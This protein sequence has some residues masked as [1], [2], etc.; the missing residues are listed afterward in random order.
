ML[1]LVK[2]PKSW[3]T[4]T[5]A[6]NTSKSDNYGALLILYTFFS[7]LFL[8]HFHPYPSEHLIY[9]R[10]RLVIKFMGF[11]VVLDNL[12]TNQRNKAHPAKYRN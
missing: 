5:H 4:P 9:A 11:Q 8:M 3:C 6:K 7:K 10:A 1:S 12:S 2:C